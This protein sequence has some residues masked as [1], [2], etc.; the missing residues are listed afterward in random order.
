MSDIRINAL[1]GNNA[2]RI[3]VKLKIYLVLHAILLVYSIGGIFA[4]LA[5]TSPFLSVGFLLNYF[6]MC[7]LSGIFAYFWQQVLKTLPLNTAYINKSICIV[8]GFFWGKIFFG[9]LISLKMIAGSCLILIG[10][11]LV[12]T[13]D[14]N[15]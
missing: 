14:E 12:V 11:V 2:P 5:A 6:I 7:F 9:E 13:A 10:M 15:N 3:R 8:W 4:K 1:T